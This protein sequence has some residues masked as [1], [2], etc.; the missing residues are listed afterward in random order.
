M[1][2]QRLIA[3]GDLALTLPAA[4]ALLAGMLA[5]RAWRLAFWW[6]VLFGL[7][8]AL[9]GASKIVFM[10][11]GGGWPAVCFKAFSGH[12]AG[13]GAI[14]PMLFY[15]LLYGL[16]RPARIA[17]LIAGLV[18]GAAVAAWLVAL[19]EHSLAEAVAGWCLGALISP[20]AITLAGPCAPLRPWPSGA[21]LVLVFIAGAWLMQWAPVGYWM[22]LAARILS[23]NK[24]VFPLDSH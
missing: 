13:V 5:A 8:V 11:W 16:G 10:G 17:G 18:L 6:S 22:I 1:S 21:V 23:G 3:L 24:H 7:A 15:V 12:A 19:R 2:S 4:A 20:L 9:V 14:A